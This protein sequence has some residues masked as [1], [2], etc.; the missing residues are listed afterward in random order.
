VHVLLL[1]MF[2][3]FTDKNSPL[4]ITV[5]NKSASNVVALFVDKHKQANDRVVVATRRQ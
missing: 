1:V 4:D 3:F 5:L 2:N